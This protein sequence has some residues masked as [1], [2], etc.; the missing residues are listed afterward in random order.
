MRALILGRSLAEPA[1]RG[2]LRALAG[3]GAELTILVPDLSGALARSRFE[4]GHGIRILP[5]PARGDP[6]RPDDWRWSARAVRRAIRDTRPDLIQVE[7]EPWTAVARTA[8]RE[9]HKAEIPFITLARAPWPERLRSGAARRRHRVLETASLVLATNTLAADTIRAHRPD[10]QVEIVPQHGIDLP[11]APVQRADDSIRLG[12]MGRLVPERGLDLLLRAAVRLGAGWEILVSG[13]GP[14]QIELEALVERLGI[15]SRVHWLGAQPRAQ[16][17]ALFSEL[18]LF[19][20]TPR[21]TPEW[22]EL[23]ATP[24]R[25]AMAHGLPVVATRSGILPELLDDAGVLIPPDDV[26]ALAEAL[27]ALVG[28]PARRQALG[29][30]G[31]RRAQELLSDHAVASRTLGAWQQLVTP[32]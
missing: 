25:I 20:A 15:A 21:S 24:V 3:Q 18:D 17:L 2:K 4:T 6:A 7:E 23:R 32:V 8:A 27:L 26:D 14:E 1:D 22:Q 12:F 19:V 31:R 16:R 5:V 11:A 28:D 29:T 13:T 9:A 10:L 30:A